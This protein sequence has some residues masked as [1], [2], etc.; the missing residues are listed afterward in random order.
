MRG[1]QAGAANL[2]E[3]DTDPD[4]EERENVVADAVLA[5]G[6]AAAVCL[7]QTALRQVQRQRRAEGSRAHACSRRAQ[8]A[9]R[10]FCRL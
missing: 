4:H 5:I 6:A 7:R 10:A 8:V 1:Q 9:A 2:P 3:V